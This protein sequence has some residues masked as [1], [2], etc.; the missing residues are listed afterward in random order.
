[1]LTSH[2][3]RSTNI[4]E[5]LMKLVEELLM[6]GAN[7]KHRV[8]FVLFYLTLTIHNVDFLGAYYRLIL[9]IETT[10]M[11]ETIWGI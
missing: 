10:Y 3:E 7:T 6:I 9:Y 5:W 1:M 2:L 11:Y 8:G 4:V